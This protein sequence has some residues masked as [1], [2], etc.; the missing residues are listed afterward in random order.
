MINLDTPCGRGTRSYPVTAGFTLLEML[1]TLSIFVIITSTLLI[2]YS[3]FN[4]HLSVDTL[5][6]EIG[7]WIRDAQVSA[8]SVKSARTVAG[9]YPGYGVH[10]TLSDPGKFIFFADLDSDDQY[11]PGVCGAAGSECEREIVLTQGNKIDALCGV[12]T[13]GIFTAKCLSP[14]GASSV[15][16]IVFTR[17]DPDAVISGDLNGGASSG[18]SSARITIVSLQGYRRTVEAWIT[19]QISIQ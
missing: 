10:F 1:V 12:T 9:M 7:Q 3:G 6:H 15:F 18:Y 8:M 14:N 17:P 11:D 19:G 13:G 5:A 16:D 4:K 2:S